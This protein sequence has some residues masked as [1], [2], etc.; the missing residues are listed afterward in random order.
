MKKKSTA[1]HRY[2]SRKREQRGLVLFLLT[3][4]IIA[5]V[6]IG[7]NLYQ[8]SRFFDE[9]ARP[10]DEGG[11]YEEQAAG[12]LA[13]KTNLSDFR[14][15]VSGKGEYPEG[16]KKPGTLF[17]E[18]PVDNGYQMQV[19]IIEKESGAEVYRSGVLAPG[20]NESRFPLTRALSKG[21]HEATAHITAIDAKSQKELG[22]VKAELQ[23]EVGR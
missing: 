6:V 1:K 5:G 21:T 14:F 22:E 9:N 8:R 10:I 18:N 15:R 3:V 13:A 23:L 2:N 4:T 17:I 19:T 20:K 12:Q 11:L 7:V 16:T